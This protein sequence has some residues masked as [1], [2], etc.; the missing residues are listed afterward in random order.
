ML[1][2][3]LYILITS[4]LCLPT[5]AQVTFPHFDSFIQIAP[6]DTADVIETSSLFASQEL[7]SFSFYRDL[8]I[9]K[10]QT[11]TL[12]EANVDGKKIKPS[13]QII[14][15]TLH[16]LF[17]NGSPLSAGNHTFQ[18]YY[19]IDQAVTFLKKFD[20]FDWNIITNT[21]PFPL[22]FARLRLELPNGTTPLEGQT[23]AFIT[24]PGGHIRTAQQEDLSF[25]SITPILPK[26]S[27]TASV[28]FPKGI[29]HKPA[30]SFLR[31]PDRKWI[32]LWILLLLLGLYYW[33][34]WNS[35]GR[36]PRSRVIRRHL[37]P[38]NVSA[39]KA[40]YI[41]SMGQEV[42]I[43]TALLSLAIK[44]AV[45]IEINN[46]GKWKGRVIVRPKLRYKIMEPL[47]NEEDAVYY[48][49]FATVG[50]RWIVDPTDIKTR[51]RIQETYAILQDC[52]QGDCA[53][54]FFERNTNYNFP[55]FLFLLVGAYLL[56]ATQPLLFIPYILMGV[57]L[58]SAAFSACHYKWGK[59]V[60]IIGAWL[61][62]QLLGWFPLQIFSLNK[63]TIAFVIGSILGGCFMEWIRAYTI[64]GRIIMDQLE[65]FKEYLLIGERNRLARTNPTNSLEFFCRYLPYAY[66]LG[67]PTKW[68]RR[69][70][71]FLGFAS[72]ATLEENGL[73]IPDLTNILS[74]LDT[75]FFSIAAG[76]GDRIKRD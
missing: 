52:L 56:S 65:G 21:T 10:N 58:Y 11:I 45:E 39:V 53:Q 38:A 62:I 34:S 22:S 29:I 28:S 18:L 41:R 48:G 69:F 61:L 32:Y 33:S 1:K 57:A 68:A 73:F 40:Q 2:K 51:K 23:R 70:E 30:P 27:F 54:T 7:P 66:A 63:G 13:T 6:N 16:V 9:N 36:D 12:L 14:N 20:R 3:Y 5:A 24:A 4:F 35:V 25:W 47:P 15:H 59:A 60:L 17:L 64:P 75:L 67:I 8:P 55:S 72:S 31:G 49:L 76:G 26:A 46:E 42:S 37:P 50:T 19:K 74:E 43:A 71:N 44:G